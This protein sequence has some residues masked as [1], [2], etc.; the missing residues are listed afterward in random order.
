[1]K[2]D[3]SDACKRRIRTRIAITG[4]GLL[5]LMTEARVL[6][7]VDSSRKPRALRSID[8]MHE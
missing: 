1:M 4:T 2:L 7:S 5:R 6:Y 8:W 3:I